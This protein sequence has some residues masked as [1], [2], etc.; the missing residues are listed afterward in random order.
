MKTA[1]WIRKTH[2]FRPDEYICSACNAYCG[3]PR[4]VCPS[5]GAA[6]KKTKYVPSWVD[7]AAML[8]AIDDDW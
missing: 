6:M 8:E 7:E 5:C 1:Y 3:K 2:L 4:T